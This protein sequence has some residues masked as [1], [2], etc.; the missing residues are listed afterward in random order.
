[1]C[2]MI[3]LNSVE[4]GLTTGR[5]PD[6]LNSKV[7]TLL[8]VSVSHNLVHDYSYGTGS[9]VVDNSSPSMV[10]FMRHTLLLGSISLD[11]YDIADIVVDEIS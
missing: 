9:D 8:N 5:V 4:E 1:M 2:G 10:V 6:V 3:C 7:Y 11:V